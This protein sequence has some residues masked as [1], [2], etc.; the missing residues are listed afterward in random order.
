MEE[1][2]QLLKTTL[3]L[4]NAQAGGQ[5]HR[6]YL[7]QHQLHKPGT[8]EVVLTPQC[9]VSQQVLADLIPRLQEALRLM[10][11]LQEPAKG[12]PS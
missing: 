3:K 9:I 11:D 10:T 6:V 7:L 12:R 1:D 2:F 5:L 4:V 8:G